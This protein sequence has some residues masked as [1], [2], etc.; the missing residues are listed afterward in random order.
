MN[1]DRIQVFLDEKGKIITP[2]KTDNI[3]NINIKNKISIKSDMRNIA[4]QFN[5]RIFSSFLFLYP[6]PEKKC[7]IGSVLAH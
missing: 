3:D 1:N 6:T 7:I 4:L 2:S 5:E